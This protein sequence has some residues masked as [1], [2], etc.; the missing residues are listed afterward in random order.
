MKLI[1]IKN[2]FRH[3]GIYNG[4]RRIKDELV[5]ISLFDIIYNVNTSAL[6]F[7]DKYKISRYDPSSHKWYQ[8]TYYFPLK[9]IAKFLNNIDKSENRVIID[10]GTG[11]GKPL[12]ILNEFLKSRNKLVGVELDHSFKKTFLSNLKGNKKVIFLNDLVEELSYKDLLFKDLLKSPTLIVHNK[13]S[14]SRNILK[15]DLEKLIQLANLHPIDI[16]YIY[17]NPEFD[18]LFSNF[19][20]LH[21]H[22]GWHV[23]HNINLYQISSSK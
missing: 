11:Y 12:I 2:I 6:K 7:K 17:S 23:N 21:K 15:D 9:R 3:H 14:F 13:N 19:D 22:T 4:L 8:P 5:E 1:D 16:F 20:L 18:E 10:L